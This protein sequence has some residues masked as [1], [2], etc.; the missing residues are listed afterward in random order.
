M[1]RY[2]ISTPG[3]YEVE[4]RAESQDA[5]IEKA[6]A[7]WQTLPRII[8]KQG[9]TRVF[10]RPNG[11]RY[12][13][14]P[15]ASFTD[16]KKVEQV[17][18]GMTAGDVT[19]K[20]ID[21]SLIAQNP[22]TARASQFVKGAPFVGS[23]ADELIGAI[24]GPEAA[25]GTR[26]IQGAM[27][28]QRPGETLGLNLAGGLAGTA[29]AG[30]AAPRALQGL[31]AAALGA[32]SRASKIARGVGAGAALGGLEGAI[33]G[34]GEGTTS[35][36]RQ[37]EAARGAGFGAGFGGF[38]GGAAPIAQEAISNVIGAFKRSDISTISKNLSISKD[39]AKVIKNAF[40]M[41]GDIQDAVSAIRRA[42]DEGTLADAGVAAR[43][44]LDATAT[45]GARASQIVQGAVGARAARSGEN[46]KEAMDMAMG[47]ATSPERLQQITRKGTAGARGEAYG[48]A[49]SRE[50]DW[51]S[52][53]GEK[54]DA[55]LRSTPPEAFARAQRLKSMSQRA[56]ILP[57]YSQEF[58]PDVRQ[59]SAPTQEQI[60]VEGFFEEYAN[61]QK[62]VGFKRPL[63]DQIKRLGGVDPSGPAA[64]ELKAR[65][66]T[67]KTHPGLFRVGGMKDL[68][69]LEID[70]FAESMRFGK[71]T[72][73]YADP[74]EII[75]GL[76]D[77]GAGRPVRTASESEAARQ[78]EYMDRL[79]PEYESRLAALASER[80]FPS[81]PDAV[82]ETFKVKTVEDVDL[83]K[84]AL[85][86]VARTG[87]GAG[88][89]GGQTSLGRAAQQRAR[90]IRDALVEAVPEYGEALA[91]SS[92]AIRRIEAV[93]VGRNMLS[94]NV[95]RDSVQEF[96]RGATGGELAAA[97]EGLR[98]QIEEVMANVRAVAS[99]PNQDAREAMTAVN[100]MTTRAAK[101]K[102]STILGKDAPEFLRRLDEAA[103]S[104]NMRADMARNSQTAIRTAIQ[105]DVAGITAPNVATSA[106]MGE[107]I[108]ASKRIVQAITGVTDEFTAKQRQM[109]YQDLARVLT[110]KGGAEA[111]AAL[112]MIDAAIG[113]QSLADDE[114]D[115]IA[116]AVA[117]ALY[118][119]A[120]PAMTRGASAEER[121]R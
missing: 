72:G 68:D 114:V 63:T 17:L 9:T 88:L 104:M 73:P 117:L 33:Y 15:G 65:G 76:A 13:V 102:I 50:I 53:A 112:R 4:I 113:Q 121:A 79:Y 47:F 70:Q 111:E 78:L 85:D 24:A 93:D 12:V 82:A 120:V 27:E 71:E 109:V 106:M 81:A 25:A 57:D 103:A 66:V 91:V 98:G 19:R 32:G 87:E 14:S 29:G 69:N 8:A 1:K 80:E 31:G 119:G 3:G 11:Q 83:I 101:D 100:R 94:P 115:A 118:G 23:Y 92:D 6:R 95:T 18:Q 42:G 10:E 59:I 34:A 84:R 75:S 38:L 2:Q 86:D 58:A 35:A 116:Q 39:A 55:L 43:A 105:G 21:E 49:Y 22:V 108:D 26:A 96:V 60:D 67:S 40:E 37:Q 45:S 97:K 107:P 28:R 62:Q 7:E 44:L 30:A 20:A 41:G 110:Q 36:D 54:L 5:A 74:E 89:L 61:L 99:D 56:D 46:L 90:E 48:R 51:R 64:A 77:E 16:P 52:P